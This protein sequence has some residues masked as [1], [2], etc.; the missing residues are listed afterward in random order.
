MRTL[1]A[2]AL[3]ATLLAGCAGRAT[4]P[5]PTAPDASTPTAPVAAPDKG[6]PQGRFDA[7]LTL[8]KQKKTAEAEKAF[9]E[10]TKDFPN[11]SGPQANLG[12]IFATTNRRD[13]AIAAFTRAANANPSNASAFNWL[14]I[15]NREVGDFARAKQSYEKALQV[16]PGYAAAELNLGILLEMYMKQPAEALP[17]YKAYQSLTG[18]TDLRVL[19]W[20]AEIEANLPKEPAV[21]AEKEVK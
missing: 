15:L 3:A 11:Y 18:G 8:M 17:H 6:D 10:L 5:K 1:V 21:P 19:P 4:K 7:A 12:I 2:F 16:K 13:G 14:G 20:I 9:L